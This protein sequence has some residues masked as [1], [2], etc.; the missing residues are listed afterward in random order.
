MT[1]FARGA[2]LALAICAG[3][4]QAQ[5]RLSYGTVGAYL[6]AR[7]ADAQSD[8]TAAAKFYAEALALEPANLELIE[9]TLTAQF[10][11]GQHEEAARLGS[12]LLAFGA[13]SQAAQIASI[14]KDALGGRYAR[15]ERQFVQGTLIGALVDQMLLAWAQVGIGDIDGAIA[16]FDKSISGEGLRAFAYHQKA[17]A[18]GL[19]GQYAEAESVLA[20]LHAL[21]IAP[22]RRML[23][24]RVEL[25]SQLG[26]NGR[27]S[28]LIAEEL[29]AEPD[30][31]FADILERLDAG[32]RLPFSVVQTPAHGMA[33]VFFAVAAALDG[34][35]NDKYTLLYARAA[36]ALNPDHIDALLMS[37][38]LLERMGNPILAT[39]TY[40]RVPRQ[41]P[42]YIT[43]EIGRAAA[44]ESAA[45]PDAAVEVLHQLAESFPD[46]A[47]VHSSL[48]DTLRRMEQYGPAIEA[49]DISL[50]ISGPPV[51][52]HWSIYFMRGISHEREGA[53]PAAE[54]DFRMALE[55]RPNEPQVLN[56]LG[57]SLVEKRLKLDEALEMITTAAELRPDSGHI[58]D[59]LGWVL[60]RLGRF[61]EAV[62]PME[63]AVELVSSD[64]I[65]ND[66]LGD[67]YWAVGRVAEAEFQ[68]LRALS[69]D[70]VPE[71]A[72][73][74]RRKLEVGLDVVLEEEGAEPIELANDDG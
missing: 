39:R 18:L 53:W 48:G 69:F 50:E 40:D 59:S 29:G 11:L 43:A 64:P 14:T 20:E 55:L 24:A 26:E 16:T 60:Y 74:I 10:A 45:K 61:E 54:A 52:E 62:A 23:L 36:E 17:L 72:E 41:A 42:E 56:Y 73:R 65:I 67:V 71:E 28:A 31:G 66:H 4:A 7:Q 9:R 27:A 38:Q 68:W 70:P 12:R 25:L 6:A 44:L 57:Y 46:T 15:I 63:A 51:P 19:D 8:F 13:Q 58:L 30:A 49:Y 2:A 47:L 1:F 32:E 35:A 3:A 34:E 22:S 5:E 21:D 37:G 33:E